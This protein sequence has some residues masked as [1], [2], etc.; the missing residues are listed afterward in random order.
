MGGLIRGGQGDDGVL[1]V[2]GT[3][4]HHYAIVTLETVRFVE[5]VGASVGRYDRVDIFEN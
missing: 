4:Y 5:E 3:C 2:I 1:T